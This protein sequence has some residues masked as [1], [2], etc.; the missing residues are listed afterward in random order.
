M[1]NRPLLPVIC[2]FFPNVNSVLARESYRPTRILRAM[3]EVHP[4]C[5]EL[6]GGDNAGMIN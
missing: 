4:H 3:Q 5:D 6:V 1:G 2:P